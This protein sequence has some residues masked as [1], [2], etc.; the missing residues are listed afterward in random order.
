MCDPNLQPFI[1]SNET[2][3]L[4]VAGSE[5]K[6]F[7]EIGAETDKLL[8]IMPVSKNEKDVDAALFPGVFFQMTTSTTHPFT[9]NY[10][11]KH[12]AS[13]STGTTRYSTSQHQEE[14]H[15]F[16]MIPESVFGEFEYQI[17]QTSA[18][19]NKQHSTKINQYAIKVKD[20]QLFPAF[21]H[22]DPTDEKKSNDPT[23]EKK[24]NETIQK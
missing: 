14:I 24:S 3:V 12:A 13:G 10:I 20:S 5:R 22:N 17:P 11:T 19:K 7:N 18:G 21:K 9:A 4:N 2:C 8:Y 6:S 23:N 15:F 16:Y 1:R